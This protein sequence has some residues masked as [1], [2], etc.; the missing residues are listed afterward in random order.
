MGVLFP[1]T[2]LGERAT[3][4]FGFAMQS[5]LIRMFSF[6]V[7]RSAL[8]GNNRES[9]FQAVSNS[10]WAHEGYLV[11]AEW[12]DDPEFRGELSRLSQAFGIGAIRLDLEDP[13]AGEVLLPARTRDDLDWATL[14]KLI[15]MNTDTSTP[16]S[17]PAM[18]ESG[19]RCQFTF[20]SAHHSSGSESCGPKRPLPEFS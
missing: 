11:A 12:S 13:S 17:N 9:F 4:R 1:M 19:S 16:S 2:A 5:P 20:G 14:D 15:A 7:K 3:A 18:A 8:F 6:E 10:S